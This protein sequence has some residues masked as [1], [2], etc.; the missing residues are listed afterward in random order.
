MC[1]APRSSLTERVKP[2][3][4]GGSW[5]EQGLDRPPVHLGRAT[6]VDAPCDPIALLLIDHVAVRVAVAGEPL[7]S[8]WPSS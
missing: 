7:V 4:A 8:L 1:I 3:G 5:A 2:T 6:D